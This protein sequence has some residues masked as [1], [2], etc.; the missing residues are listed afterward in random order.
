MLCP[1]NGFR[2]IYSSLLKFYIKH[3]SDEV[4]N[5]HE[6]ACMHAYCTVVVE[7]MQCN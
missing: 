2:S 3:N 7:A 1:D 6:L 5:D 4:G